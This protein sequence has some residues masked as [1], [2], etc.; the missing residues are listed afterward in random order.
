MKKLTHIGLIFGLL[1]FVGLLIWQGVMDVIILLLSSG[2]ELL[3]LP[4]V[5]LPSVFPT[6]ESWRL[7]FHSDRKPSLYNSLV[8]MWIG[9]AVNNLLPVATIGGEIVKAR[10]ATLNG[11]GLR[12]ASASVMVDKTIQALALILWG[13]IGMFLLLLLSLDNGIAFY[14]FSGFIILS[15]GVAGFFLVQKKGMF[16]LFARLGGMVI[17]TDS[18]DEISNG[19]KEVDKIVMEI[20]RNKTSFLL[21]VIYK[22]LGLILQ[23]TEVWLACYLLGHPIGIIEAMMLKSLTSTIS[24]IAFIIP[25]AYGIQEGAYIMIGALLGFSPDLALA[26]SLAVRVRE[27]VID[28]P[29]LL[30]WHQIESRHILKR[31]SQEF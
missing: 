27:V 15:T 2:W 19:A 9:R 12:D 28:V 6:T 21:A 26:L 18:W 17:K 10:L 30:L 13:L 4:V 11:S 8:A 20:Y 1:L 22:T 16:L 24:D 29:G 25:N 14:V 5:W 7:C 3:W 23:T 31:Q